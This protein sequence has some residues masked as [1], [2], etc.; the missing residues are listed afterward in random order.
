MSP[1]AQDI[2]ETIAYA[3]SLP[4]AQA[5]KECRGIYALIDH[6]GLIRYIGATRAPNENFYRRLYQRHRTG[7]E[8]ESHMF[9]RIYNTGRM[10]RDPQDRSSAA[11]NAKAL[12]NDFIARHCRAIC[13]PIADHV[14]IFALERQVIALAPPDFVVWNKGAA[15]PYDEPVELV[16]ALL[17]ERGDTPPWCRAVD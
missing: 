7:S 17:M 8:G 10:W 15:Q 16:D 11:R 1:H 6:A 14:N 12:R 5:P 4:L 2:L 3:V 9:S 13:V